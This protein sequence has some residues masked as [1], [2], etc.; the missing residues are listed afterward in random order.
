MVEHLQQRKHIPMSAHESAETDVKSRVDS[1]ISRSR[2]SKT[3]SNEFFD[4]LRQ[5][6]TDLRLKLFSGQS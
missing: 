3:D 1:L 5:R 6:T 4:S 2:E